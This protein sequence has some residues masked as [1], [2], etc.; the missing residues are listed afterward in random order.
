MGSNSHTLFQCIVSSIP[1]LLSLKQIFLHLVIMLKEMC[2]RGL[3]SGLSE[4]L[5]VRL[6]IF[7]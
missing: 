7:Y 4:L 1:D 3:K 2:L 5:S 6:I